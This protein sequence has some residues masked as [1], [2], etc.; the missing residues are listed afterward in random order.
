MIKISFVALTAIMAF[1]L[2]TGINRIS[3]TVME[4]DA[5]KRLISRAAWTMLGWLCYV[6]LISLT[7]VLQSGSVPPRIPLL[8]IAP[9]F[10]AMIYYI[11]TPT[12]KL[13]LAA[14]PAHWLIYPQVFRIG[15]ELLLAALYH[16]GILP[17]AGTFEGYNFEIVTALISLAVGTVALKKWK[18]LYPAITAW[19]IIGLGTLA[20][21]VFIF[22]SHAYFP[23][24]YNNPEKLSMRHFGSFPYTLLP[25]FLMPLAVFLH[26]AS[27]IK[28]RTAS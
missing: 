2:L 23:S 1:V 11:R 18:I 10:A 7:G 28:Q 4:K 26:I 22:V 8:L 12:F 21:I 27:M 24:I 13:L 9:L 15:V 3:R 14:T 25:G 20:I 5:Q 16:E 6:A 17:K 19:N